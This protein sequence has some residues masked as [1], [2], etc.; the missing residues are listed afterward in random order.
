MKPRI[1]VPAN[2]RLILLLI[3][4]L[5][6]LVACKVDLLGFWYS[7]SAPDQRYEASRKRSDPVWS[8]P[9]PGATFSFV[10][11]SDSHVMDGSTSRLKRLSAKLSP[12][13]FVVHAGDVTQNGRRQDWQAFH[14]WATIQAIPVY[15]TIGNHDLYSNGWDNI[16]DFLSQTSFTL[17]VG[18][19]LRLIFLDSGNATLGQ[20]QFKWLIR[21]LKGNHSAAVVVVTHFPMF[22]TGF[23]EINWSDPEEAAALI[24]LFSRFPVKLV[25]C[26]HTHRYSTRTIGHTTY[27][28]ADD[29]SAVNSGQSVIRILVDH[30]VLSWSRFALP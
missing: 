24:Q 21:V 26:G 23:D 2:C 1:M 25:L 28:I 18:S 10:F 3:N 30:G 22:D 11:V 14:A 15:A 12:D 19:Q 7:E 5:L 20:K 9:D 17:T 4:C 27:V 13:S 6:W 8:L 29:C 16:P